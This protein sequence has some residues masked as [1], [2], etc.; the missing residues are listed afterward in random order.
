ML[1]P[2]PLTGLAGL[3][4]RI[5]QF[6]QF[7]PPVQLV[8]NVQV[9]QFVQAVQFNVIGSYS[10]YIRIETFDQF[11]I[12]KYFYFHVYCIISISVLFYL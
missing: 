7:V 4:G 11:M 12:D 1:E 3:A 5:G 8:Q 10:R 2:I 9:V 6:I